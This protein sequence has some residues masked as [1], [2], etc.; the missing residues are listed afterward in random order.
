MIAPYPSTRALRDRFVLERRG[1]RLSRE[2]WREPRVVIEPERDAAGRVND[3]ATIFLTGRECPWRCVMCDLWRHASADDTEPGA[4]PRQIERAVASLESRHPRARPSHAKL[5]NAGSLFDPRAVPPD[6][7]GPIAQA[8]SGFRHVIVESHP[9]LV[10]PRTW[11]FQDRLARQRS[12]NGPSLEVAM[13]LET[14]HPEALERLH[15]GITLDDFGSAAAAL[16]G[17]GIPLRAFVLVHP[18]FVPAAE[19]AIWLARSVDTALA[20]GASVISLIPTRSGNGAMEALVALGLFA[21][22]SL[23][24]LEAAAAASIRRVRGRARVFADV[25]DLALFTAC[26]ACLDARRARL[27]CLNLEQQVPPPVS[28]EACGATTPA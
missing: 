16:A 11:R 6:D 8:V 18:P 20:C 28:C 2:P 1:E 15:K 12:A 7:D 17:H 26:A 10:G 4:I 13:G 9:R 23:A 19:Q 14:A 27:N 5:Y 22:P 25:W 21:P 3:V 24:D